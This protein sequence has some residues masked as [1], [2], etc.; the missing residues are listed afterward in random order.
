MEQSNDDDNSHNYLELEAKPMDKG[1]GSEVSGMSAVLSP[2]SIASDRLLLI[3]M[4]L[5]NCCW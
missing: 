1:S 5:Q 2:S 4:M 3:V